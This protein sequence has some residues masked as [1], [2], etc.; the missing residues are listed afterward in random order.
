MTITVMQSYNTWTH[1]KSMASETTAVTMLSMYSVDSFPVL[2][3][4]CSAIYEVSKV[5]LSIEFEILSQLKT[6]RLTNSFV[7]NMERTARCW[8]LIDNLKT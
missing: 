1:V 4:H 2:A 8:N 7:K 5:N 6:H 3:S